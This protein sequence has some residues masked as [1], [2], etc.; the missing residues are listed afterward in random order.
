LTVLENPQR[1]FPPPPGSF[2]GAVFDLDGTLLDTLDDITRVG[3]SILSRR[4]FPVRDRE[5][6][7]AATG[8]GIEALYRKLLG[9]DSDPALVADMAREAALAYSRVEE[10]IARPFPGVPELLSRLESEGIPMAVLSNKPQEAV[11]ALLAVLLPGVRFHAAI[12][13][14]PGRT[15]KPCGEAA[16]KLMGSMG[17]VPEK[18]AMVGDGEPDMK[19]ALAAGM[20]PVGCSWGFTPPG[21]LLEMGAVYLVHSLK[22]LEDILIPP[23]L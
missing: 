22:E 13:A 4:G 8:M 19:T 21:R 18:T 17:V 15:V 7:R 5:T 10:S 2:A 20:V 3:N 9:D 12:G 23:A 1:R 14:A 6:F 16:V 11:T